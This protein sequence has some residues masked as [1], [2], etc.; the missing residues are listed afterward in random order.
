[1]L[2]MSGAAAHRDLSRVDAYLDEGERSLSAMIDPDVAWALERA[3]HELCEVDRARADRAARLSRAQWS[4][5]GDHDALARLDAMIA[6]T[7][8]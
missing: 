2:R 4:A 8:P 1:M 5:L 6:D 3:A 7:P